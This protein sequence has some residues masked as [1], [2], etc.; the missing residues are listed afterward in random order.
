MDK[1]MKELNTYSDWRLAFIFDRCTTNKTDKELIIRECIMD[2]LEKR[3]IEKFN[4]WLDDETSNS[5]LRYFNKV[6]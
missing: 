6:A 5:M 2:I 3:D 1:L 4:Q